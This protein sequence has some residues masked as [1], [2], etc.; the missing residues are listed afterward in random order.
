[1]DSQIRNTVRAKKWNCLL[2]VPPVHSSLRSETVVTESDGGG[3]SLDLMTGLL[4]RKADFYLSNTV[5]HSGHT[6][7]VVLAT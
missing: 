2:F 6:A 1:M 4:T 5:P 3:V 7:H